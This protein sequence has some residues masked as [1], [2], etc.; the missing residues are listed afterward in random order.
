MPSRTLTQ[1][2][3]YEPG[4]DITAEVVTAPVASRRFVKIGGDRTN[5]GNLAVTPAASGDRVFGVADVVIRTDDTE[6][7]P[8]GT[9]I[10]VVRGGVVRVTAGANI[11]AGA[12]VQAGAAGVAIPAAAGTIVGFAVTGAING[13]DAQIALI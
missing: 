7:A 4:R 6:T 8:V 3:V 1:I 10:R 9:L 12:A 2:R 13:A 11:T 5:G